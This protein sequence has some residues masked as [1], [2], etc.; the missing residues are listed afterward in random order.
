MAQRGRPLIEIDFEDFE[1]LCKIQCTRE[2]IASFFDISVDTI[3]RRCKSH[4]GANFAVVFKR[5]SAGGKISLRRSMFRMSET[6]VAMAIWLSKQHLGMTEKVETRTTTE[7]PP[8]LNV[9][10]TDERP[11]PE[12]HG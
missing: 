12:A 8:R 3:E 1:A 10:E 4:Y 6:N 5:F 7:A 2:E 9:P 11:G